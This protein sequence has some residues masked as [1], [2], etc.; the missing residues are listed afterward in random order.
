MLFRREGRSRVR[1]HVKRLHITTAGNAIVDAVA[2]KL[3]LMWRVIWRSRQI[4]LHVLVRSIEAMGKIS[5]ASTAIRQILQESTKDFT[6]WITAY[7]SLHCSSSS[8][9]PFRILNI[10]LVI[11]PKRHYDGDDR[12]YRTLNVPKCSA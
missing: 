9:L 8:G 5:T 10:N 3:K 6:A 4:T 2:M 12:K 1:R 11:P 7:Y